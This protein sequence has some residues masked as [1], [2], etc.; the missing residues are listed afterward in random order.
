LS[1]VAWRIAKETLEFA[2]ADLSGGGAARTG[3][4]WNSAGKAVVYASESVALAYLE[5]LV[6]LGRELPRNRY[7]VRLSIPPSVWSKALQPNLRSLPKTWRAQPP[8]LGSVAFGD[9]WLRGAQSA[10]LRLPSAIVPEDNNVL[11]NPNHADARHITAEVVREL[12]YDP[13][14][15]RA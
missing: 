15:L 8:G 14:L 7:L 1:A 6:H 2:A 3:G 4:R 12:R 5:T 11:I 10:V 9:A 13:R